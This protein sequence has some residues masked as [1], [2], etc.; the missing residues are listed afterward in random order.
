MQQIQA[1]KRDKVRKQ[2]ELD[3]LKTSAR[4][5]VDVV[6]HNISGRTLLEHLRDAP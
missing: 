4:T 3:E 2:K 6:D 5:L 1:L